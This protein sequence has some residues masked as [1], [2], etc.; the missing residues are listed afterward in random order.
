[1][2]MAEKIIGNIDTEIS[3]DRMLRKIEKAVQTADSVFNCD[4]YVVQKQL[5]HSEYEE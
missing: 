5:G 4:Y 1:M 3:K 2:D